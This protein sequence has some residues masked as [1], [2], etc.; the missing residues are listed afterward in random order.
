MSVHQ[1]QKTRMVTFPLALVLCILAIP[2][3]NL[4]RA[5]NNP[6]F[7]EVLLTTIDVNH[8]PLTDGNPM[9]HSEAFSLDLPKKTIELIWRVADHESDEIMFSVAQG[10]EVHAEGLVDGA[11]TR[12]LHGDD[13]R[14][15]N[16]E[17]AQGPF[18]LEV[19]ANVIDR[20]KKADS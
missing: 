17:G 5:H 14:I 2:Q 12:I 8:Q 1:F 11:N 16:V 4:V 9:I 20:S 13:I 18:R 3:L 10:D 7:K 15:I 6:G 19:F